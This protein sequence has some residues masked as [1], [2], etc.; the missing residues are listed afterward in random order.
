M[1]AL[2]DLRPGHPHYLICFKGDALIES[3]T[4]HMQRMLSSSVLLAPLKSCLHLNKVQICVDH[5]LVSSVCELAI[6]RIY[7]NAEAHFKK[8][9]Q[10]LRKR[11]SEFCFFYVQILWSAASPWV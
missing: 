7:F 10:V 11:F 1:S 5:V 4:V 6:G 2:Q 3:G 9:L 8:N